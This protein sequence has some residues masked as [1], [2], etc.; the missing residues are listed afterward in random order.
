ML[1][2]VCIHCKAP[3][4]VKC[5]IYCV[6][7]LVVAAPPTLIKP[8]TLMKNF[9]FEMNNTNLYQEVSSYM[10]MFTLPYNILSVFGALIWV[11]NKSKAH[12]VLHPTAQRKFGFCIYSLFKRIIGSNYYSIKM[13]NRPSLINLYFDQALLVFVYRILFAFILFN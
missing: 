5:V 7:C 10:H 3:Q 12:G 4:V 8:S 11:G 9:L 6:W 2:N 1:T 13:Y